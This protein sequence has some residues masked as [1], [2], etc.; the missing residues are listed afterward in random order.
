MTTTVLDLGVQYLGGIAKPVAADVGKFAVV[1]LDSLNR[2]NLSYETQTASVAN[3]AFA[4]ALATH[5]RGIGLTV[6]A[7]GNL[8][9]RQRP[10]AA[11]I[12][13]YF[14]SGNASSGSIGAL[15]WNLLGTGTPAYARGNPTVMGSSNRGALST[16]T[17]AID[18]SVLCLG[19]T[20]ARDVLPASE[21]TL[22]Q[23]AWNHDNNLTNK[24]IFFGLMGTF[25]AE[26]VAAVDC[27]GIYY[28]SS[29]S[30]NYQI[31]ARSSSVGSPVVTSAVVPANTAELISIHQA[32]AGTFV[33]YVG[34]TAIGSISSGVPTGAM[35]VGWRLENLNA[36]TFETE[37]IG[38]FG[39]EAVAGN[40]YDDDTFLEA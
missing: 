28:D 33:F 26:A 7:N 36:G 24:R 16:S 19:D 25:A 35:N 32:S 31:I 20:E 18:R 39:L 8:A 13:D 40:T 22:L 37:N 6:D 1:R 5:L 27:L 15:G 34:N 29:V 2:P 17:G 21:L 4:T 30:P 10:R 12:R 11:Q 9:V 38:Y 3:D 14:L 23:C